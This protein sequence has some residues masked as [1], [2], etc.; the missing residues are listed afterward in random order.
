MTNSIKINHIDKKISKKENLIVLVGH[1][2]TIEGIIKFHKKFLD[3]N[4]ADLAISTWVDEDDSDDLIEKIKSSLKPVY[5]EIEDFNFELTTKIFGNLNKFDLMFGKAA[6]STRAQIYKIIKIKKIIQQIEDIQNKKYKIIFKSRP[7]ML[8]LSSKININNLH[9]NIIFEATTGDWR[10]DRS[11]RFFYGKREFFL[12]FIDNIMSFSKKIW[13][14][15]I[16]HPVLIRIPL[17]EQ[18]LKY[19]CD[20]KNI[21]NDFFLPLSIV[22]RPKREPN[23]KDKLTILLKKIKKQIFLKIVL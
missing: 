10:K 8:I 1:L 5:F 20:Y 3:N 9:S 2:R 21:K 16:M 17:Q 11:D 15:E 6:L 22:W 7:D 4:C 14:E 19:C 23:I 18:L 13:D 12:N